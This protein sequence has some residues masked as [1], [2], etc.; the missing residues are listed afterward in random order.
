MTHGNN[1]PVTAHG[2]DSTE[3][4]R[5][6]GRFLHC[7]CGSKEYNTSISHTTTAPP[8]LAP[9]SHMT[10]GNNNPATAHG[11]DSTERERMTGRFFHCPCG[12]KE[13]NTSINHTPT[14]PPSLAP[15]SHMTHGNNNPV[16]AHGLDTKGQDKITDQYFSSS[17]CGTRGTT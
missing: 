8:Y 7:P 6:T 14:A 17:I 9:S 2:L 16:T 1:N 4:E 10:H 3:Q 13:Y 5:M 15:S 11:I 12:S